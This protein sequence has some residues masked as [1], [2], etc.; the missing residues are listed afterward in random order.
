MPIE[1]THVRL[2]IV[3]TLALLWTTAVL[4]RLAYLQ[5]FRHSEYLARAEHQQQRTI[6]ITPPRGTIYDRNM[7]ALAMSI[8]VDSAFAVPGEIADQPLA[9]HLLSAVLGIPQDLLE[10]RLGSSRSF[11]WVA[12]KLAPET[13]EAIAALN[14][15]GIYF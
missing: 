4:G 7:H 10:T 1:R 15:K 13:A 9:A 11:V 2:L 3:A 5:L 6:E 8:P 12:R 14:L